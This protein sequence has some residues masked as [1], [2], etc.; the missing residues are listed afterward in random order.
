M[1]QI[2]VAV[3]GFVSAVIVAVLNTNVRFKRIEDELTKTVKYQKDN[4]MALLRLTVMSNEMPTDER[5]IAG[6]A[7]ID[8]GGNG[9]VKQY[10]HDFLEEHIIENSNK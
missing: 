1:T 8:H 9:G 7:Y 4:Y 2:L 3:I 10:Y 6:K 5:I